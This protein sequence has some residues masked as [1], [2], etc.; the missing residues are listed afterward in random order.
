MIAVKVFLLVISVVV[1]LRRYV[2]RRVH[3]ISIVHV[4]GIGT[5]RHGQVAVA[6]SV[7][8]QRR[9]PIQQLI[10]QLQLLC[11]QIASCFCLYLE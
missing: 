9:G 6:V 3:H 5:G 1:V 11:A 7:V 8:Q 2:R 4:H 10:A